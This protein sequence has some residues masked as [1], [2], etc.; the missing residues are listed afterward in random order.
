MIKDAV[1]VFVTCASAG[2][3]D[4]IADILLDKKL[5]SCVNILPGIRSKYRW[6]GRIE[7]ARE[8]LVMAKTRRPKFAAIEKE[9]RRVHSY[10]VPEIIAL[11][12]ILGSGEYLSWIAESLK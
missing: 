1:L 6:K 3:A 10:E 7:K 11:P 2:E 8:I 4:R 9:V 5:A 12:I